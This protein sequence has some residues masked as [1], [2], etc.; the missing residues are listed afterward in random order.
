MYISQS[1]LHHLCDICPKTKNLKNMQ[2]CSRHFF[3][4]VFVFLQEKAKTQSSSPLRLIAS[5]SALHITIKKRLEDCAVLSA[6][7]ELTLDDIL[8]VL[9]QT[10]LQALAGFVSSV[11]QAMEQAAVK[12]EPGASVPTGQAPQSQ[13]PQY[14]PKKHDGQRDGSFLNTLFVQNDVPET[15]YHLRTGQIDF[16]LCDDSGLSSDARDPGA[17]GAMHFQ[18]KKLSL[19]HYPYHLAGTSRVCWPCHNEAA[20][21]R[22][23]WVNQLL[24]VFRTSLRTRHASPVATHER[25]R[26]DVSVVLDYEVSPC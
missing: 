14:I 12:R 22:A 17:N 24:N 21:A 2:K 9:T 26:N 6:R 15:S 10:Q 23:Y 20:L 4:F 19:D 3:V 5:N 25:A 11:N 8:W 18:I 13:Q 7:L 1:P 16:H